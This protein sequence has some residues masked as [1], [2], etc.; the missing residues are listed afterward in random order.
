MIHAV[1]VLLL[2]QDLLSALQLKLVL[3]FHLFVLTIMIVAEIAFV[4]LVK[5]CGGQHE[6]QLP[7]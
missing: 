6:P 7:R 4:L 5:H 1:T 3:Q 2:I